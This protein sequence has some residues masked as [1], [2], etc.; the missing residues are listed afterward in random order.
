MKTIY[1]HFETVIITAYIAKQEIAL[2]TKSGKHYQGKIQSMMTEEGFYIND[3]FI[4]WTELATIDLKEEYFHF[5][6]HVMT[7]TSR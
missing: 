1:I 5:W 3:Q 2:L 6:R 7:K 4:Y